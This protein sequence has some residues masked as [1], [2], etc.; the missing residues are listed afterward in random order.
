MR[1]M[2]RNHNPIQLKFIKALFLPQTQGLLSS[3]ILKQIACVEDTL[4]L[5]Y[6]NTISDTWAGWYAGKKQQNIFQIFSCPSEQGSHK[7]KAKQAQ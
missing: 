3:R 1:K 2:S 7:Q 5:V 4:N 6:I